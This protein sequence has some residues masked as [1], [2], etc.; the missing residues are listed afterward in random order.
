M[1]L[2][3]LAKRYLDGEDYFFILCECK[4]NQAVINVS[5]EI[6]KTDK[7]KALWFLQECYK[8]KNE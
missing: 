6:A 2:Q 4:S 1:G 7:Q 5:D 8:L 3:E